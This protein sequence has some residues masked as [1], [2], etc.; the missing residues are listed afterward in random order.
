MSGITFVIPVGD[1]DTFE[2]CFLSS[3]LLAENPRS[4]VL[5]Q[6]RFKSASLAFNDA[7]DRAANDIIVFAH[8]DVVFP[9]S[10]DR[11]FLGRLEEL[12]S[13]RIPIG[14]VGCVGITHGGE[15][16][17][18]IY[19]YDREFFP[20]L[21]LPAKIETVDEMVISFRKSSGLRFDP[22][23]PTFSCY[24]ADICLEARSR[25]LENFVVDA[26]CFHQGKN[27][28]GRLPKGEFKDRAYI[29]RKWKKYLPVRT[30]SGTIDRRR[31][32][33]AY[34]IKQ[35][36]RGLLLTSPRPWWADLPQIDPEE[37]LRPRIAE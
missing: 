29:V 35:F 23:L 1:E 36:F 28:Q 18:H 5:V 6:R 11:Q 3:P 4:Q 13:L 19:R 27:I 9:S 8:Q 17:G 10:W 32:Y 30:L 7:I 14:I 21:P 25:N 33:R 24:G 37:K 34:R 31:S 20:P 2:K 26:P 15:Q 12:E 16:A 22:G